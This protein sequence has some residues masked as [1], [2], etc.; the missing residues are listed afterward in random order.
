MLILA[1]AAAEAAPRHGMLVEVAA[2][3]GDF[4]GQRHGKHRDDDNNPFNNGNDRG[5][6]DR[7]GGQRGGFDDDNNWQGL[8]DRARSIASGYPNLLRIENIS[9]ESGPYFRARVTTRDGRRV[10]LHINAATGSYNEE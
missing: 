4:G 9:H 6:N 8:A 7:G 10:D 3:A 2:A 1:P 5:G